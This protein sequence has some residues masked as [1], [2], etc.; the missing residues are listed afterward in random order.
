M[1]RQRVKEEL[2]KMTI[3]ENGKE[4]GEAEGE[5]KEK[6]VFEGQRI[7]CWVVLLAGKR[8]VWHFFIFIPTLP[9]NFYYY[10]FYLNSDLTP[11]FVL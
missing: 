11:L 2:K 9:L 5:K 7:H 6:D 4:G 8:E 3:G 1:V 10:F